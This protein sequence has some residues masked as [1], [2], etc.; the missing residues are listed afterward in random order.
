[1]AIKKKKS[2]EPPEEMNHFEG[3]QESVSRIEEK[4]NLKVPT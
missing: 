4:N 1:M 3:K 2:Y